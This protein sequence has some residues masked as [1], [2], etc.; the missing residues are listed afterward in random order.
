MEYKIRN[1]KPED[2]DQVAEMEA[3]GFPAAEACDKES[4]KERIAAFPECFFV[5][6]AKDGRLIGFIN[7]AVSDTIALP[8]AAYHDLS[9]HKP[10]GCCQQ[11]F[12]LNVLSEYRKQHIGIA[13]MRRF[14]QNA[15]IQGREA[16][17]LTCK[18]H[19]IP[20]Y[21]RIGYRLVGKAD[22][23]HGGAVWYEMRY[24]FKPYSHE[25]KYYETDQMGCVH[26][27]NYIRW[28]EES[29]LEFL[30]QIGLEYDKME[31]AGIMSPVLSV[32]AEYRTMTRF[33]ETVHI[34]VAMPQYNG[35]KFAVQYEVTDAVSGE[36]R[37][38]GE[39][40]HCFLSVKDGKPVF[41]KRE[42]PEWHKIMLSCVRGLK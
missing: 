22:S 42:K 15:F 27:S 10:D 30:K 23:T 6:E 5:A 38:K 41:L 32:Q 9:L 37:C 35:I 33:G 29:R 20:Y 39:T 1:V 3:L 14:I 13:L 17:I 31:A 26:H 4:F 40:T 8:D 16:V 18:E 21:S 24:E 7:G 36:V 12:G 19:M 2:L 25:V 28:F 11:L 34:A